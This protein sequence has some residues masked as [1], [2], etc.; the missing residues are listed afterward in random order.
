M[1]VVVEREIYLPPHRGAV[2][3]SAAAH[4]GGANAW[5]DAL[6]LG[7]AILTALG[8]T[9]ALDAT[10]LFCPLVGGARGGPRLALLVA[11]E[12]AIGDE[13]LDA[14]R[15]VVEE[16]APAWTPEGTRAIPSR[17]FPALAWAED[18]VWHLWA[19]EDGQTVA[20]RAALDE[21]GDLEVTRVAADV[22]DP[23]D[24]VPG[25]GH[26]LAVTA[27]PED[28]GEAPLIEM[29]KVAWALHV[30]EQIVESDGEVHEDELDYLAR[31]FPPRRLQALGLHDRARCV[32]LRHLASA[33]LVHLLPRT[34][35]LS[36]VGLFFRV[37]EADRAVTAPEL[38][39]LRGAAETLGLPWEETRAYLADLW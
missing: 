6:G 23:A 34:E 32:R 19:A 22:A 21:H 31:T 30:A 16:R 24:F 35:K 25:L 1:S 27:A 10:V 15:R 9:L 39:I 12:G 2:A 38:E 28:E 37:A 14:I 17:A 36:L 7:E 18:A 11:W 29:M 13:A 5:R 8:A 20:R 4:S 26:A 33:E 3:Y